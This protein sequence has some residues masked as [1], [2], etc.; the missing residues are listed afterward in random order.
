MAGEQIKQGDFITVDY[1]GRVKGTGEIFDLT[2]EDVALKEGLGNPQTKFGSVTVVVGAKHVLAGLDKELPT[3]FVGDKKTVS[4]SANDG[5][6][7]RKTEL[8]KL[9]P[10]QELKNQGIKP[11]VGMPVELDRQRGVIKTISGGRVRV[12]FNHPL[13]GKDLEYEVEIHKKITDKNEQVQALLNLH[14]PNMEA[15]DIKITFN[16]QDLE[17]QTP[18]DQR[19]RRFI[20]LTEDILAKD[21]LDYVNGLQQI[22][23]V[24]V[25]TKKPVEGAQK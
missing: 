22:K 10:R 19:T 8:I 13:A 20:N 15:K 3:L 9:V 11:V 21:I 2:R 16:N 4:V 7:P 24:D 23:F 17:I 5:F 25:F 1:V 18:D 6:G 14:I 12:D